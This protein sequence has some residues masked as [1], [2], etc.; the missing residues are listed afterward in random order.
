MF[1]MALF[2]EQYHREYLLF[3]QVYKSKCGK[4][5]MPRKI[6]NIQWNLCTYTAINV[7][8]LNVFNHMDL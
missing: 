8:I 4:K 6:Q 1:K 7:G 3:I 5:D 2:Y